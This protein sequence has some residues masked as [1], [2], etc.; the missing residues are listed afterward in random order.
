MTEMYFY[1]A[2]KWG[3]FKKMHLSEKQQLSLIWLFIW[4]YVKLLIPIV[5][6]YSNNKIKD[7]YYYSKS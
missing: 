4:L 3:A 7:Y 1:F 6:R 2:L 5:N